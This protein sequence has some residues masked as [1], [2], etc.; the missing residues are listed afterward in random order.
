M[1]S[2]VAIAHSGRINEEIAPAS[3]MPSSRICP[4]FLLYS[5]KT[6]L[7]QQGRTTVLNALFKLSKQGPYQKCE[8]HLEH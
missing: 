7:N 3:F 6:D 1:N 5:I 2:V 4:F 8:L